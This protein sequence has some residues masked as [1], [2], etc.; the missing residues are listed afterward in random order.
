MLRL[1]IA[2]EDIPNNE[3]FDAAL[4]TESQDINAMLQAKGPYCALIR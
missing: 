3:W 1:G 4:T 2:D